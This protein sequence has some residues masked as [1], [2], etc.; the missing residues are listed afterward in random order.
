VQ[1]V[2]GVLVLGTAGLTFF[3]YRGFASKSLLSLAY[4]YQHELLAR[5]SDAFLALFSEGDSCLRGYVGN[6]ESISNV[7]KDPNISQ[8]SRELMVGFLNQT[9]GL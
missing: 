1:V 2:F 6:L 9:S 5:A 4:D 3:L 8:T 7:L